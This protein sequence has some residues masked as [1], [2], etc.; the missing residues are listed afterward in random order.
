MTQAQIDAKFPIVAFKTAKEASTL[1]RSEE[2]KDEP[3]TL[4]KNM[5]TPSV[6][7]DNDLDFDDKKPRA[8]SPERP[9]KRRSLLRPF[10]MVSRHSVHVRTN[11][12]NTQTGTAD[13]AAFDQSPDVEAGIVTL[14]PP[15]ARRPNSQQLHDTDTDDDDEEEE[16]TPMP[17]CDEGSLTTCAI[18]I[19]DMTDDTLVRGLA[20]GHIFHPEC[21]DPWLLTRQARCPLCKTSFYMPKPE[22]PLGPEPVD[23]IE[24]QERERERQTAREQG[25]MRRLSVRL[26]GTPRPQNEA[27]GE[28]TTTASTEV[29]PIEVAMPA[30]PPPIYQFSVT[31]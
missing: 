24:E 25:P 15:P 27:H 26:W 13:H 16:T 2:K 14:L 19:D 11:S 18:C 23:V 17:V 20:C 7:H 1:N 12:P 5:C 6:S 28:H 21:I 4:V 29:R 10:S 9:T 22:D 3:A 30:V 31:R 8:K